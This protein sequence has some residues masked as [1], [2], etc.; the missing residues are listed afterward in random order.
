MQRVSL[1][2]IERWCWNW[3]FI[4]ASDVGFK[5]LWSRER[6]GQPQV[7]PSCFWL[8]SQQGQMRHEGEQGG[9]GLR[10]SDSSCLRV[11]GEPG[12]GEERDW[13]WVVDQYLPP[14]PPEQGQS[15]LEMLLLV[16][17]VLLWKQIREGGGW[18]ET[19]C[20]DTGR[21]VSLGAKGGI[22]RQNS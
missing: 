1:W 19:G 17:G 22:C 6:T 2:G 21:F 3:D 12:E 7:P 9:G 20:D 18:E 15:M 10:K 11:I 16:V 14:A 13:P 5:F 4:L 8:V